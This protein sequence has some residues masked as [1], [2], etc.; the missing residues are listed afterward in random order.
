[1]SCCVTIPGLGT[2]GINHRFETRIFSAILVV[3]LLRPHYK[4]LIA[5]IV[6]TVG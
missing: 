6:Q 2:T 5:K 1:M 4:D 3:N